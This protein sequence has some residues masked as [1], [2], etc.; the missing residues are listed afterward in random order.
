MSNNR[1]TSDYLRRQTKTRETRKRFLIICEGEKTEV[2][3]FKAF[4]VPKKIEVR[5]KGEGKNSLSLVEKAIKM[6]DNLKKDEKTKIDNFKSYDARMYE[7]YFTE[8]YAKKPGTAT[9]K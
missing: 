3:Y 2:N 8:R 9:I 4:D 5:V 7:R 1:N 6:I